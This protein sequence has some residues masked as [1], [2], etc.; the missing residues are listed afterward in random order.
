[1]N[2][3]GNCTVP[4]R[5]TCETLSTFTFSGRLNPG[6]KLWVSPL[7]W[8]SKT[9]CRPSRSFNQ[10]LT[11]IKNE[12]DGVFDPKRQFLSLEA[13]SIIKA[14]IA[15][16]QWQLGD[17]RAVDASVSVYIWIYIKCMWYSELFSD[18]FST[19]QANLPSESCVVSYER[20]CLQTRLFWRS[21]EF[22]LASRIVWKDA[23]T[24][25]M[26]SDKR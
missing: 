22:F 26:W 13:A 24:Y 23:F 8:T 19:A 17:S 16:T 21:F 2:R 25:R 15:R 7:G 18:T 5:V 9:F 3:C 11:N 14:S 6:A 1:M 12:D 10:S 4:I 20:K